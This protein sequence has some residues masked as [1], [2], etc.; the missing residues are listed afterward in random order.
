MLDAANPAPSVFQITSIVIWRLEF[1]KPSPTS[2]TGFPALRI[3]LIRL[4]L[5]SQGEVL[6]PV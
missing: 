1:T 4:T 6:L 3:R 5:R 2:K